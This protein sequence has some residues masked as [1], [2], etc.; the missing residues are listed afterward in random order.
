[1]KKRIVWLWFL[2]GILA[3]LLLAGIGFG[4]V[5]HA[6]ALTVPAVPDGVRV[7]VFDNSPVVIPAA[8]FSS[9]GYDP[10]SIFFSFW[11]GYMRG[12]NTNTC[13]KAPVYIPMHATMVD[14]WTSVYDNDPSADIWIRLYRV[15][16]YSGVVDELAYVSTQSAA[17]YIQ[18]PWD[19][20][21]YHYVQYPDYS[22]YVGVCAESALTRLY[23]VRI[24]Y[25][26]YHIYVP[27]ILR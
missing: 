17:D 15:D 19:W 5:G 8:A 10:D 22:Y 13:F 2:A 4:M 3:A 26:L 16:N 12:G 25:N 21:D 7:N 24:Y 9:D 23:S 27:V 11:S 20:I 6:T 14:M 18:T 1:M